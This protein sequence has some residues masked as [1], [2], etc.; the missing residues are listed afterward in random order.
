MK[1][2]EMG[3]LDYKFLNFYNQ[4]EVHSIKIYSG[5]TNVKKLRQ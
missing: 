1:R 2:V 5:G 4:K 3:K